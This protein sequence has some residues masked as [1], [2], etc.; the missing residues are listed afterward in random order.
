MVEYDGRVLWRAPD[1][2]FG[3]RWERQSDSSKRIFELVELTNGTAVRHFRRGK[4]PPERRKVR[5]N[6]AKSGLY[7]AWTS[8]DK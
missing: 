1:D 8:F 4:R 7:A 5:Q 2:A 3:A 6:K